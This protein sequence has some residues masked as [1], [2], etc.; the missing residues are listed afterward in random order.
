[1]AA[2]PVCGMYV[3]ESTAELKAEVRGVTYY[4]C[5]ENC[6][7]EFLAPEKELRKLKI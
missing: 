7:R 1:V 4:F 3:D 6:M 5:S 2:D